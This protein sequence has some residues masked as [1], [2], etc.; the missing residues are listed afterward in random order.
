MATPADIT[1]I[2]VEDFLFLEAEMLDEWR[3]KEWLAL[4]T[5][6]AS[7]Y[8]PATDLTPEA[9]P[10]TSL[11]YI[12]DDRSRLESRVERLMKR[13]AHSEYP[14]SKTR[15]LVTNVRIRERQADS[16]FVSAAFAVY[17]TK[18]SVTDLYVGSNR[19]R[20]VFEGG[21][22]KIREKRCILDLDG[23]KPQGRISIL[24]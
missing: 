1:R 21:A 19:Y 13:T 4:F 15:H 10:A 14:R 18:D 9:S 3:L 12:A 11:F 2:E 17:R 8:V 22:L 16:I 7:Y 24:L 20:M 5:R 6:N 23:L